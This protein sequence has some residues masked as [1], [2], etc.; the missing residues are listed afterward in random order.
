MAT[1][2]ALSI[3]AGPINGE[4]GLVM[5]DPPDTPSSDGANLRH[6]Q[7]M[8][9][10]TRLASQPVEAQCSVEETCSL[11]VSETEATSV[12]MVNSVELADLLLEVRL[13]WTRILF[14]FKKIKEQCPR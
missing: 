5:A 6:H 11:A 8:N 10:R 3:E 7:E 14:F 9:Y 13:R 2:A 4:N 1:A 12:I